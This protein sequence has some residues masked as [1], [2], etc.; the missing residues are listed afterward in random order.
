VSTPDFLFSMRF[1]GR[2]Q[3]GPVLSDV[4]ANVFQN[5][6]CAPDAVAEVVRDLS[7]AVIPGAE[8]GEHV[9]VQFRARAGSCEVVVRVDDR[10][11][12]RTSRRIP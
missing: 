10:E 3:V 1:A 8:S 2:D 6:G 4:A 9:D 5:A 12:W 7:A 11:I